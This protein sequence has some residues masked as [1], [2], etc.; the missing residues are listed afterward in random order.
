MQEIYS[1]WYER[2]HSSSQTWTH[3]F[4]DFLPEDLKNLKRLTFCVTTFEKWARFDLSMQKNIITNIGSITTNEKPN[5]TALHSPDIPNFVKEFSA[6]LKRKRVAD[7]TTPKYTRLKARMV[8]PL[9]FFEEVDASSNVDVDELEILQYSTVFILFLPRLKTVTPN[10]WSDMI[11][12]IIT[13]SNRNPAFTYGRKA[14]WIPTLIIKNDTGDFR[15]YHPTSDFYVA[16]QYGPLLLGEVCSDKGNE[17][18]R[19][20]MFLQAAAACRIVNFMRKPDRNI[21]LLAIYVNKDFE[22][23]QYLIFQP[24]AATDLEVT[25]V[26]SAVFDLSI[27]QQAFELCFQLYNYAQELPAIFDGFDIAKKDTLA[28]MQM[29]LWF[30]LMPS[31]TTVTQSPSSSASA[32]APGPFSEP[33][34]QAALQ[35]HGYQLG[36]IFRHRPHVAR[37]LQVKSAT[38]VVVKLVKG[39]Q[40][41]EISLLR[42]LNSNEM[43]RDESN[44]TIPLLEVWAIDSDLILVTPRCAAFTESLSLWLDQATAFALIRQLVDGVA[45]L[46]RHLIAH[47]DLKPDN[48]VLAALT[49]DR[50]VH[51]WLYI[52]DFGL[53]RQ[54]STGDEIIQGFR[55]IKQ[56]VGPEVTDGVSYNPIF[57]DLW[58]VGKM[59]RS[60][61][62]A[63]KQQTLR[64]PVGDIATALMLPT[65]NERPSMREAGRR[66]DE[67]QGGMQ[68]TGSVNAAG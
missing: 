58:P 11:T 60:L 63:L 18:G 33:S 28:R 56:W 42:M 10:L 40:S 4:P 31:L 44:H 51:I 59:I 61:S 1:L 6:K 17:V 14:T 39:T 27:G 8:N 47:C 62:R 24:N 38:R 32:R 54:L 20:R 5:I 52:I 65:P 19:C 25:I 36:A 45:F 15:K 3:V 66:L 67:L 64:Q 9:D 16:C 49:G 57:A 12:N 7:I 29:T 48:I 50:H 55:G 43:R 41:G 68:D 23:E 13:C 22:A 2:R 21:I 37:A 35:Q 26:C 53:A 34:T 46:H 30:T